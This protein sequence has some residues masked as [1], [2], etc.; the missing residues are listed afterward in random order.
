MRK[1]TLAVISGAV[2]VV[3]GLARPAEAVW[4]LTIVKTTAHYIK[5]EVLDT[6]V[7]QDECEQAL[8]QSDSIPEDDD[9]KE[10]IEVYD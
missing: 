1:I 2:L 9:A 4:R 3:G 8:F 7:T 6:F 5:G 10:C